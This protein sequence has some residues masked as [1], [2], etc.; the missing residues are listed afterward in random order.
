MNKLEK[1][2][3]W[4][5][6]SKFLRFGLILSSCLV[7]IITF[8]AVITR[9][10]NINFL[11]YEEILIICAFWLYMLGTAY[12][13]FEDS[14]IKADVI[15]VMMPDG[16]AKSLLAIIRNSLSLILGIIF[17]LWAFQLFQWTIVMANKTPVWRIPMTVS[18]SSLL[19]GLTVASFYHAV[20]LYN[21]IKLFIGKHITK[22]IAIDSPS[23][24][25]KGE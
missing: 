21:D 15:V 9:A 13:S 4:K 2:A 22:K 14:H 7:T 19:F 11:G 16:F 25:R 8:A 12:G 17:L 1:T 6:L 5:A 24:E 20:Y 10:L 23:D 18:Q 3:F